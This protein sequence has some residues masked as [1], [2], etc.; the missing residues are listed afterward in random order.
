M[1]AFRTKLKKQR[2]CAIIAE[3]ILAVML[4]IN[5]LGDIKIIPLYDYMPG[6][7]AWKNSY[8]EKLGIFIITLLANNGFIIKGISKVLN[9]EEQLKQR[10]IQSTDEL[11]Q[12]IFHSSRSMSAR[13]IVL[14]ELIAIPICG[15]FNKAIS[16]T[17]TAIFIFH[18]LVSC[19]TDAYYRKKYS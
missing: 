13:I 3:V 15:Y 1:N 16:L 17:I 8:P 5:F 10:Y 7:E 2:T 19:I 4:V 14:V 6:D 11:Q 9:N 12:M 18:I